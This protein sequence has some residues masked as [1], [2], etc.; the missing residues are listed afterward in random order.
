MCKMRSQT[1]RQ[2]PHHLRKM[3]LN[4]LHKMRRHRQM[5]RM[6]MERLVDEPTPRCVPL[7]NFF[8]KLQKLPLT[9]HRVNHNLNLQTPIRRETVFTIRAF[10]R[11]I[12]PRY[13]A[14][15]ASRLGTLTNFY[16]H[17]LFSLLYEY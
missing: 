15:P 7:L 1:R 12:D 14:I 5:P 10:L 2:T 11:R 8:P 13:P 4:I 16:F 6:R 9:L 17:F 3:L